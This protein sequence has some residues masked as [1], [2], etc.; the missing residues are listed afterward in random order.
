MA[1]EQYLTVNEV[2]R[3][4]SCHR[5]TVYRMVSDPAVAYPRPIMLGSLSRWRLT[6]IEAWEAARAAER[7]QA[8]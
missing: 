4:L 5:A 7:E 6:E 3:R 1:S 8:A 2:A